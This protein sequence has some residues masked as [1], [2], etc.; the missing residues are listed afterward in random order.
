M[1]KKLIEQNKKTI[2]FDGECN[3]CDRS[4]QLLLKNDPQDTFRFVSLQ[5]TTG[6]KIQHEYG[7]DT[8]YQNSIIVINDYVNYMAK[9]SAILS[10]TR[11]M[12]KLWPLLNIFW[13]IPK[14]IRDSLYDYIAA[15]RY[16][17]FGRKNTCMVM[18]DDIRHK[19]IDYEK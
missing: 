1:L 9:S 8:S 10:L 6:K 16:Q 11:S 4:V 3:L 7:I 17:W 13:V 19:F 2:L 12:G 14:S 15:R 5:S 18:T